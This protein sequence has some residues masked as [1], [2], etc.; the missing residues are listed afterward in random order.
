MENDGDFRE[1]FEVNGWVQS[2]ADL[3]ECGEDEPNKAVV[4]HLVCGLCLDVHMGRQDCDVRMRMV[5]TNDPCPNASLGSKLLRSLCTSG[6][7]LW[8]G[9][10]SVLMGKCQE[11]THGNVGLGE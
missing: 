3:V 2:K 11:C 10:Y 9:L 8:T 5:P 6:Q 1:K 7:L 4:K